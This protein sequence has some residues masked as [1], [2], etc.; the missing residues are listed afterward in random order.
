MRNM[1]SMRLGFFLALLVFMTVVPFRAVDAMQYTTGKNTTIDCDVTLS[2]GAGWRTSNADNEKLAD[3]NADDGNR[4]FDKWDM[5]TNKVT[6][7]ADI[8]VRHKN[9]GFFIRPKVFYDAVYFDR[10]SNNSPSTNNALVAGLINDTKD[11]ADG[12]QRVHGKN[13]E[14]LDLFVSTDFELAGRKM[15][16]RVGKQ[17]ISWGESFLVAGGISS[18]QSH[19][20]AAAAVAVGTELKEIYLPSE[21]VFFQTEVTDKLSLSS[22]Y[23]WKW[24]KS[25][26]LEPGSFFAGFDYF[27]DL[28]T[29][30]LANF[31]PFGIIPVTARGND[32]EARDDG[33]YG[34]ALNY[35]SD[36]LN[37]TEFGL[38]YINYHDKLPTLNIAS[39]FSTYWFTYTEDIK[40]YGASF[41]SQ[42]GP[43]NVS[44][45][46]SSRDGIRFLNGDEGDYS[47]AQVSFLG[48]IPFN[49]IADVLNYSGEVATGLPDGLTEDNIGWRYIIFFG[50]DWYQA[51]QDLDVTMN[52]IY[53]DVPS[54]RDGGGTN[55]MHPLGIEG[56]S[57]ASI[58]FNF[59]YKSVYKTSITYEDRLRRNALG[60]DHDTLA[61]TFSYTF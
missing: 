59:L 18:A 36:W 10:N 51:L 27:A 58:G 56:D 19:V 40:L 11:W 61:L 55:N 24:R 32:I 8:D 21:S 54:A 3:I 2:Y 15:D 45:E 20:D 60:S 5:I 46:V 30:V 41:S 16:V 42:I 6:M 7:L 57:S 4:N 53:S 23:Q 9:L 22:Y 31:P 17:S 38:Y 39:N 44:G 50:I 34:I 52:L 28:P 47:Q 12:V 14:I 26:M 25:T 1:R 13:A 33:Q 49:P 37:S 29:S 48:S 43:V 35:A